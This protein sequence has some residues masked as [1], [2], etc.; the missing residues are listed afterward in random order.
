MS[1]INTKV[2]V[3][4]DVARNNVAVCYRR[5]EETCCF[6][7]Q[8]NYKGSTFILNVGNNL[9][10]LTSTKTIYSRVLGDLLWNNSHNEIH[11][12]KVSEEIR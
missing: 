9:H 1:T 2:P 10:G 12:Y 3:S 5:F 4:Y 11:H 6:H 8:S 7:L